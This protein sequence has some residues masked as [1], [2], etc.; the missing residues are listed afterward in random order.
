MAMGALHFQQ[1]CF[2]FP[3]A[4]VPVCATMSD[5]YFAIGCYINSLL[6]AGGGKW[7]QGWL[8]LGHQLERPLLLQHR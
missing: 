4:V 8:R 1:S 5:V 7:R 2:C 6:G 3:C